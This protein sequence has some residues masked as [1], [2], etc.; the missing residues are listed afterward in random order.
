MYIDNS[1]TSRIV[2]K[3]TGFDSV[4]D[5]EFDSARVIDLFTNLKP[6][7]KKGAYLEESLH[8]HAAHLIVYDTSVK[9]FGQLQ[10]YDTAQLRAGVICNQILATE[11]PCKQE[12]NILEFLLKQCK[13]QDHAH[14]IRAKCSR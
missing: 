1:R 10:R 3:A 14:W 6:R 8:S 5:S 2:W 7:L 4:R 13:T 11:E 12:D 9:V